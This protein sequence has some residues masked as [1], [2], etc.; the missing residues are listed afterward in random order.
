LRV[1]LLQHHFDYSKAGLA[2][3]PRAQR[4]AHFSS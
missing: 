4:E 3:S 1:A 2:D